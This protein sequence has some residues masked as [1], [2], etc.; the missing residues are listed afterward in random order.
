A[1]FYA[2]GEVYFKE[3]HTRVQVEHPVTEMITGIDI[4]KQQ[5]LVASGEPLSFVQD[6]VKVRGHAIE[7]R[8]NAE[9]PYSFI[10]CPGTVTHFHCPGGPGIRVDTH[11]YNGYTVP[12]YYD[13]MIGKL[14]ALGHS[15]SGALTRMKGALH[16]I[17]IDGITTNVPL[18]LELM[19]DP[20]YINA[21]HNIHYL[22][23][24]LK[25]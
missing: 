23:N 2:N 25:G 13:S 17:V 18:L 11:L 21:E 6:D 4:V 12:P 20:V 1:I 9:D 19:Q 15:R 7:C 22:E 14:L 8:I 3:L 24:K 5:L 10:P 16:E